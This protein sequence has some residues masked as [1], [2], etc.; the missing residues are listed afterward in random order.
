MI[1]YN[2]LIGLVNQNILRGQGTMLS[3]QDLVCVLLRVRHV[4]V[5]S[6]PFTLLAGKV[7]MV[8]ECNVWLH[9]AKLILHACTNLVH[10]WET[11]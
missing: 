8:Q 4:E 7:Q 6:P 11:L 1:Q 9:H 3:C 10:I 2:Y 5:M